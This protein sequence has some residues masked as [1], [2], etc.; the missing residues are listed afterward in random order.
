MVP[1]ISSTLKPAV[2]RL[3]NPLARTAIRLGITPNT[4]TVI[5]AIGVVSS[6]IYFFTRQSFLVGTLVVTLFTLS[7]LF[8]GAIAR[9]SAKGPSRWGGFLDSTVDRVTDFAIT[10]SVVVPLIQEKNKVAYL[11]L[12]IVVTGLLIPY[13]R[14]KAESFDIECSVGIAERTE[15]LV[16]MLVT[17]GLH[18]LQVPY[19]LAFGFWLLAILGVVTVAQR[20]LTVYRGLHNR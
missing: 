16:I 4:V 3:I 11:G 5:G 14:A 13:I 18:G 17:V 9:I 12:I 19:A 2:T 10:I 6:S 1:M 20:A 15:R 8:D 7:D